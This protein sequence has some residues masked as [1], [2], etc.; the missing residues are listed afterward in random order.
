MCDN[1]LVLSYQNGLE[2]LAYI[3]DS[4]K[5]NSERGS[6]IDLVITDINMPS[7]NGY[8]LTKKLKQL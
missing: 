6:T 1:T 4:L 8:E 5:S 3:E 7:I 2:A